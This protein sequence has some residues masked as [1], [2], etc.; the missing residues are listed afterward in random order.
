MSNPSGPDESQPEHGGEGAETA[1]AAETVSIPSSD[2][3][4]ESVA[5]E[6]PAERRFTAPSGFDA[7]STQIIETAPEPA[8]EV[9]PVSSSGSGATPPT[10]PIVATNPVAPQVIPGR[11]ETPKRRRSWGWV[12]AVLL[13][14]AAIVAVAILGTVLLTRDD[15]PAVSQEEM[16]R[17][18]IQ[19]FDAAIKK[20]DLAT[21]RSITCGE[22]ADA[23]I[24]YDDRQWADIHRGVA[25]ARQYP[26]VASI[27]QVVVNDR[28]AE[29]NV[30]VF[31]AYDPST[32]STRSFD[33][34]FRDEQWKI[35]QAPQ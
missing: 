29:A 24:K 33:L 10:E 28:H 2:P 22:T 34:E 17:T 11:T 14:I 9:F 8:T 31:M 1:E 3:G 19:N 27:D 12:I 25:A 23:Y 21:L 6:E 35:C 5:S 4:V 16:V 26:V 15:T 18:A 30:R 32:Q 7:G 13:V 20:G